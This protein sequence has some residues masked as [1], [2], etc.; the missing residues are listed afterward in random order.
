MIRTGSSFF[1][2]KTSHPMV[3]V[4]SAMTAATPACI[5][6]STSLTIRLLGKA[7]YAK[8]ISERIISGGSTVPATVTNAPKIP[9]KR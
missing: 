8:E 3:M 9:A 6:R 7:V 4:T 1:F 2:F 5:P